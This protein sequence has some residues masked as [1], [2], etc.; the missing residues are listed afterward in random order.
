M[1]L[2]GELYNQGLGVRQDRPQAAAVVSARGRARRPH[3]MASLGL[4]A[5]DGRGMPTRP[6]A[7][8]RAGSRRPPPSGEPTA[9]YNLALLL[10][11]ARR[12]GRDRA[13]AAALCDRGRGRDRRCP[14]R[15]RRH[16]C[17]RPRRR[18]R[19]G[20]GGA[21]VPAGGPERLA[22]RRGR[23]R[24]R[25]LQRRRASRRTRPGGPPCSAARPLRGNAIAQNRLARIYATGRGVPKNLVEAAAWHLVAAGQGLADPWL[26]GQTGALPEGDRGRAEALASVRAGNALRAPARSPPRL[27]PRNGTF[28][29]NGTAGLDRAG[30][31][32]SCPRNAS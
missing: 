26:D 19:P 2:L 22:R 3:A 30:P 27:V 25:A 13:A 29:A 31:N 16:V 11:A 12:G 14:A 18:A 28:A 6:T 24:D 5:A 8:A 32:R 10:L 23:I 15:A 20:R 9:A 17:A 4:M 1:T 7:A 21:L